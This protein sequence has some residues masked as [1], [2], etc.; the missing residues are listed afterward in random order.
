MNLND[1]LTSPLSLFTPS[2]PHSLGERFPIDTNHFSNNPLKMR[3]GSYV[4]LAE[5]ERMFE[6]Y[7]S[8]LRSG[9]KSLQVGA[10]VDVVRHISCALIPSVPLS[11]TIF[12]ARC[13]CSLSFRVI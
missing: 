5:E 9:L 13:R 2:S 10:F 1:L 11:S 8:E 7:E 6:V 4:E 3:S 12:A